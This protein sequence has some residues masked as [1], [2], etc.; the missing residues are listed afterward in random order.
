MLVPHNR[1]DGKGAG[2]ADRHHG[3]DKQSEA[4]SHGL[5]ASAEARA[6]AP[7]NVRFD[8]FAGAR[9]GVFDGPAKGMSPVVI[10]CC[11]SKTS[12]CGVICGSL[13]PE[14]EPPPM[15]NAAA[16]TP[17]TTSDIALHIT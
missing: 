10:A 1:E 4:V 2:D 12:S 9:A 11:M 7:T 8:G 3:A 16:P 6:D 13:A 14:D 5:V 17:T 15:P